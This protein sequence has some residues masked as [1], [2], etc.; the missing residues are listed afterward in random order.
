L[1]AAAAAAAAAACEVKQQT[2]DVYAG[3]ES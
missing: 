2:S 3:Q 1:I